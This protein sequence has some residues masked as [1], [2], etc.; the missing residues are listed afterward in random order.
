MAHTADSVT[1]DPSHPQ[2]EG[3]VTAHVYSGPE[4]SKDPC[5]VCGGDRF[6][7]LHVADPALGQWAPP[8]LSDIAPDTA[9][10]DLTDPVDGVDGVD[11]F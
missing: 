3:T 11:G 2:G 4:G 6:I 7:A 9:E 8:R 10:V 5:G 1:P